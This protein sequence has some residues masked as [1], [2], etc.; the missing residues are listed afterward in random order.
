MNPRDFL[1]HIGTSDENEQQEH[2]GNRKQQQQVFPSEHSEERY[3]K[4]QD[5][6]K[7]QAK[8]MLAVKAMCV[9]HPLPM[10]LCGSKES[11]N[12]RWHSVVFRHRLIT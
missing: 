6:Q 2:A 1:K 4:R 3:A 8:E 5:E 11:I 7:P 10:P 9:S 12:I